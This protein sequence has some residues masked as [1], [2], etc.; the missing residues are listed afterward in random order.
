METAP[1]GRALLEAAWERLLGSQGQ[2]RDRTH[3]K[4]SGQEDTQNAKVGV[5]TALYHF[6]AA[7]RYLHF[8]NVNFTRMSEV[9]KCRSESKMRDPAFQG[10][11]GH[12]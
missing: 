1:R 9:G 5:C 8:I 10:R 2:G 4:V 6:P 12:R 3:T 11:E 7:R